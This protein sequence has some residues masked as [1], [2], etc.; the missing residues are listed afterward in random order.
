MSPARRLTSLGSL[1][2]RFVHARR[3]EVLA[4]MLAELIPPGAEVL[5]VGCGDGRI[6]RL[7]QHTQP[8]I[9]V[10]GLEVTARP[11][12]WIPCD[13]FDGRHIPKDDASVDCCMFV[14][15]LHHTDDIATLLR[16]AARV[17]RRYILVKDHLCESRLDFA[18]LWLMD[19]VGNHP[20]GV[21]VPRNYQSRRQWAMMFAPCGLRVDTW[22]GQIPLYPFPFSLLFG[23]ELHFIARLEHIN[24]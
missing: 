3:V 13:V 14:D 17:S 12:C 5:D 1:H 18:T 4:A 23:R 7:V 2:R 16:E 21:A 22:R 15:A 19:W 20:H 6:G 24:H 10:R 9:T 8:G 11:Q